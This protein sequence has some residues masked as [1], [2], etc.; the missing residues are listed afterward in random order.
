MISILEDSCRIR[1]INYPRK[2]EKKKLSDHT[3]TT[4]FINI[5][6]KSRKKFVLFYV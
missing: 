4:N 6:L 1:K 2:L 3:I 5:L